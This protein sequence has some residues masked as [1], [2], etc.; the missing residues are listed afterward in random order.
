[1]MNKNIYKL[2]KSSFLNFFVNNSRSEEY[3]TDGKCWYLRIILRCHL[4]QFC[5]CWIKENDTLIF[6]FPFFL[7]ELTI[8]IV[9][10]VLKTWCY[11]KQHLDQ[12]IY[13]NIYL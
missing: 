12:N 2:L 7:T 11:S 6:G 13:L 8:Y 4:Y 9:G 10:E 3:I 5:F 1:M